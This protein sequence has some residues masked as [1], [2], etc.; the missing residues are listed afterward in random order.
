MTLLPHVLCLLARSTHAT[1]GGGSDGSGGCTVSSAATASAATAFSDTKAVQAML[2][3]EAC[4]EVIIAAGTHAKVGALH[5]TR[6]HVVLTLQAGAEL[7]GDDK[8]I[9]GC[10]DEADWKG[11]CAFFTIDSAHNFTLRGPGT[12]AGGGKQGQHWS[13]LHVRSTVG[14]DLGG[15]GTRIHC[16]NSWWCR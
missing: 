13:T 4:T 7:E 12:L 9:K 8:K 6:S 15:G 14:V 3:D 11:W 5:L 10:D 1:S 16:T 2:D